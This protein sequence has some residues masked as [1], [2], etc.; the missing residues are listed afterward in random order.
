MMNTDDDGSALVFYVSCAAV[1]QWLWKVSELTL[2]GTY[3]FFPG[4]IKLAS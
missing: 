3:E 2:K 1:Y 4:V